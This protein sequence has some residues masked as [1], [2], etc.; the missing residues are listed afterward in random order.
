MAADVD[1]V[2]HAA[3]DPVIAIGIAAATVASEIATRIRPEIGV[4]EALM[5]A[6]DAAHLPR[7]G[8]E[9]H[10]VAFGLA[11]QVSAFRIDDGRLHAEERQGGRAGFRIDCARQWRN[12]DAARF[13]LPPGINDRAATVADNLVI[14]APGFRIDRFA[15]A[16]KQAQRRSRCRLDRPLAFAHQ[17]ADGGRRGIEQ[18]D[19]VLVDH[20]PEARGIRVVRHAF[21]NHFSRTI[22]QRAI[23]DVAVAGN[24]ADIG[25]APEDIIFAQVEH[26]LMRVGRPQQIPAG[27][28][29]HALGFTGAAGGVEDE[30]RIF[31]IHAFGFARIRLRIDHRVIPAVARHL[32]VHRAAGMAHH[33]H[34]LDRVGAGH[35]QRRIDI[36]LQWHVLAATQAF[37]GSNDEL[38]GAITDAVGDRVRC[39]PAE[40]HHVHR[41]DARA[42]QHRHHRFGNHRQVDG[43]PVALGHAEVAQRVCQPADPR[44]QLA[45]AD[46]LDLA[47][48]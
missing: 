34:G 10:Q 26:G 12:Q 15:D 29:Q 17:R 48:G 32:H 21:E 47:I 43:D 16:A 1:H 22:G 46:A 40:H 6:I 20:L 18:A 3:S 33:Q 23:H 45:I 5:V 14:P 13:G 44:V 9:Q 25:S 41:A 42:G 11:F 19:L 30:Q 4:D 37:V 7:P 36:G 24:P 39:E 27:G 2:V 35:G 31:R 8:I 38:A 28:M